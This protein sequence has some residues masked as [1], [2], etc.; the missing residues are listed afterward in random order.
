MSSRPGRFIPG[1]LG[2]LPGPG[3][4]G[5]EHQPRAHAYQEG[6]H[7]KQGRGLEEDKPHAQA[8]DGGSADSP[9]TLVFVIHA[10]CLPRLDVGVWGRAAC[11]VW[12]SHL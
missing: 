11:G 7:E 6:G 3:N 10:K 9:R 8:D 5:D 2:L 12:P 1:L 4:N